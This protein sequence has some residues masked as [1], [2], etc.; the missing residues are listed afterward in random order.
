MNKN[1]LTYEMVVNL[2]YQNVVSVKL[3][4][5]HL[6]SKPI[7]LSRGIRMKI[8][9]PQMKPGVFEKLAA[10]T[11]TPS[12][13]RDHLQGLYIQYKDFSISTFIYNW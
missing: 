1:C 12:S 2:S 10:T 8:E 6:S 9:F 7:C 13:K 11:L 4:V 3:V 5:L